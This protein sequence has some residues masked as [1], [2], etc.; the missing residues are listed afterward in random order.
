MSVPGPDRLRVV[1]VL[2][3]LALIPTGVQGQ[4]RDI[5]SNEIAVSEAEASLRLGFEDRDELAI[6]FREGRVIVDGDPL[7][8]FS[9]RDDLDQAWR[10][11]LG[12]V[13]T[14]DDGPLARA[15]QEWAPPEDLAGEARDLADRLDRILEDALTLPAEAEDPG[16]VPASEALQSGETR[17]LE[18]L[19]S[20]S[21]ALTRLGEALEGAD[22]DDFTMRIGEDV[23]VPSGEEIEG[24]LIVVD[25]NLDLDGRIDGT[26]IVT[27]G[28]VRLGEE[29]A[30]S[31]DLRIADGSLDRAGGSISGSLVDMDSR[32]E[33]RVDREELEEMR[34][35]L[36]SEIRRDIRSAVH[37]E[38]RRP[39]VFT[40]FIR[41]VG[42]AIAGLLENL[43]TFIVLGILGV[44]ALHFQR[45]RLEV[46]ATTARGAPVRSA[47]V[48]L[49]AGFFVLPVWIV[50]MIALA[51]TII[52]IPVLLAWIPLFP[53]AAGVAALLGYLAVARNVGEWVAEQEYRGLEWIRGSN[54]FYTL[55]AGLGALL[56]PCV[57]VNV[58]KV[59]GFGFLTGL[60]GFAASLVT[61]GA[62]A[63]GLGAVL[64]TRGG[65]IRPLEAYYEFEEDFWADER[66]GG[67]FSGGQGY[68]AE[69]FQA[70]PADG[71]EAG[72]PGEEPR[73]SGTPDEDVE[74]SDAPDQEENDRV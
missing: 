15:L 37:R 48:G 3:L 67:G 65:K 16:A 47:V 32:E 38:S 23:V 53:I 7:G 51:I 73:A 28:R 72:S 12:E 58:S 50:G 44:L 8:S 54:T 45:E 64:L 59:L 66:P 61:F 2:A 74:G 63:V 52:G 55:V 1:F 49:A 13:I 6:S 40:G 30:I 35:E 41:N 26:V 5:V 22:L 62:V 57:A 10:A 17:L 69:D 20:R 31:G 39:N 36:E 25:G 11:L 33:V 27:G 43:V 70:P 29:A 42:G 71:E 68:E 34:R 9:R 18:A 21:G 24:N 19:L 46:V 60:L 4:L 14:L 56:V